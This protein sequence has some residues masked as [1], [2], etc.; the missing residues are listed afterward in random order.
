MNRYEA[1]TDSED[2]E[3][4]QM[5][6]VRQQGEDINSQYQSD[7]NA[8]LLSYATTQNRPNVIQE[9]KRVKRR[10]PSVA[11][12]NQHIDS[13]I[14]G[15]SMGNKDTNIKL[16]RKTGISRDLVYYRAIKKTERCFLN[17]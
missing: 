17:V 15:N 3:E 16:S 4:I 5:L 6:E 9:P 10:D 8:S 2:S 11:N 1:L 7:G 14:D 13:W 12:K